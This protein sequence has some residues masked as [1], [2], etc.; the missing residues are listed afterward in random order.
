[1]AI[2]Y[3]LDRLNVTSSCFFFTRLVSSRFGPKIP[4]V[5]DLQLFFHL[6][7]YKLGPFRTFP[8]RS[9]SELCELPVDWRKLVEKVCERW[10]MEFLHGT[11][12]VEKV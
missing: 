11:F 7:A 12:F 5:G 1:M 3:L 4:Q 2:L 9:V 6:G 10:G 8:E